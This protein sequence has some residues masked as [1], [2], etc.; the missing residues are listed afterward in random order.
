M[1]ET[2]EK[3]P[4]LL[5]GIDVLIRIRAGELNPGTGPGVAAIHDFV[6]EDFGIVVAT[7]P[8]VGIHRGEV[9][10]IDV[11]E[12][13]RDHGCSAIVLDAPVVID[14]VDGF[15][16][17]VTIVSDDGVEG[18]V[19]LQDGNGPG[20]AAIVELQGGHGAGHARDGCDAFFQITGE[21]VAHEAAIGHAAGVDARRGRYCIAQT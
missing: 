6:V 10:G 17:G 12:A 18:S 2:Q 5:A 16:E 13:S 11:G 21:A 8:G 14:A 3:F 15:R 20:S 9:E 19:D 1:R 7:R 4:D